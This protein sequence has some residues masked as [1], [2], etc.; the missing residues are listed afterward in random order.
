MTYYIEYILL[1]NFII[2]FILIYVTGSLLKKEIIIKRILIA[3]LIGAV[4]A[5]V[6]AICNQSF[7]NNIVVKIFFSILM[8]TVAYNPSKIIDYI[9]LL[10]CFYIMSFLI[11][12]IIIATNYFLNTNRTTIKLILESSFFA[13]I[14]FKLIFKEVKRRTYLEEY[15]RKIHIELNNKRIEL[16]GFIDTGNELRDLLTQRPV[17]VVEMESIIDLFDEEVIFNIKKFYAKKEKDYLNIFTKLIPG[18]N[19]RLIRYSTISTKEDNMLGIIPDKLLI[20]SMDVTLH[21]NAI[22]GIYPEK[23]NKKNEYQALLHKD[24]L[25]WECEYDY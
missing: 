14:I 7:I 20:E 9:R 17:I 15:L 18:I 16:I 10:L 2:D 23:L 13:I 1:E 19:F 22:I 12:G 24:I 4:F 6:I 11:I 5:I 3:S 8:I 21:A 25:E